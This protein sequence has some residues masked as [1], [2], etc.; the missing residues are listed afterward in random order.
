MKSPNF[1]TILVPAVFPDVVVPCKAHIK[2]CLPSQAGDVVAAVVVHLD[3]FYF[4]VFCVVR[5]Q[6]WDALP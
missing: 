4:A 1:G 2:F 3:V 5:R 6:T